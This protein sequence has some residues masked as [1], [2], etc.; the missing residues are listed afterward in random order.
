[1]HALTSYRNV[2]D[3]FFVHVEKLSANYWLGA[4]QKKRT[5]TMRKTNR[6]Q[7]L[8]NKVTTTAIVTAG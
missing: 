7:I 8:A 2:L 6:L 3:C 1:Q 4:P 5:A